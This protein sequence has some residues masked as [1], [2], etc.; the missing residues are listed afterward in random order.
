MLIPALPNLHFIRL[1]YSELIASSEVADFWFGN[2]ISSP[3]HQFY[4]NQLSDVVRL[5]LLDRFGGAYLDAD[6]ASRAPVP[7]D[8]KNFIVEGN[9]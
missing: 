4:R 7:T 6:T 3:R 1:N 9:V 8:I 2:N 5:I